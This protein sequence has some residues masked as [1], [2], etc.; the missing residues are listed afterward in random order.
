MSSRTVGSPVITC[1][2]ANHENNDSDHSDCAIEIISI[3]DPLADEDE[4]KNSE[5]EILVKT[6]NDEL[7]ITYEVKA[8]TM[9]VTLWI[10]YDAANTVHSNFYD[11]YD[12]NGVVGRRIVVLLEGENKVPGRHHIIWDCR[13]ITNDHRILLAGTY[14]V[15]IQG[16]HEI[17]LNSQTN[18]TVSHPPANN[19]GIHY[20]KGSHLESTKEEVDNATD[21]QQQ[22]H[23]GTSYGSSAQFDCIAA[24][25]WNEIIT[26]AIVSTSTHSNPFALIFYPEESVPGRRARY[27]EDKRSFIS[28]ESA[29]SDDKHIGIRGASNSLRDMFLAILA[30]CRSG[31]DTYGIQDRLRLLSRSFNPGRADGDFGKKTKEALKQWQIWEDL[32]PK[33]G[34]FT[35]E[36]LN[37]LNVD[38]SL[39][40]DELNTEIQKKLKNYSKRYFPGKRDGKW[41]RKTETALTHYQEDHSPPLEVNSLPDTK[42]LRHLSLDSSEGGT[43]V[44]MVE[45]FSK[46]GC[47][48][49]LG[50]KKSVTFGA[51]EKW[52]I[53]FWNILAEGTGIDHAATD[54]I[55]ECGSR[56]YEELDYTLVTRDG[57]DKNETLHPA[58]FGKDIGD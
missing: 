9:Q 2:H 25:I 38:S 10:E 27:D 20:H 53:H 33:D 26:S 51:A 31:N 58:R 43:D 17:T 15:R 34:S 40:G 56:Y 44:N 37:A 21:K 30:G 42:T 7:R 57:V 45:A 16:L 32:E 1:S 22:L 48:I 28:L 8:C 6:F 23:D 49:V 39:Q 50:F 19:F 55:I 18:I 36:T 24:G 11:K 5:N 46:R 41:G 52:H 47:N 29:N 14:K 3:V 13:D 54:A 12:G 4:F 35:T